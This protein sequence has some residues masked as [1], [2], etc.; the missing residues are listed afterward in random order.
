MDDSVISPLLAPAPTPKGM[1]KDV[2]ALVHKVA[3]GERVRDMLWL[4]PTGAID[5]RARVTIAQA[6]EGEV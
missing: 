5:R 1:R 2:M 4:A 3:G 6:V